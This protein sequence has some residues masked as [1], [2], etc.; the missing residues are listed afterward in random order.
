MSYEPQRIGSNRAAYARLPGGMGSGHN[1]GKPCTNPAHDP[2]KGGHV[3]TVCSF[4]QV[5]W[6]ASLEPSQAD[7]AIT[8]KRKA[9]ARLP[10]GMGSGHNG[11]KPCTNS[12]H[13]P[14]KGGNVRAVCS[15]SHVHWDAALEP[16]QA[17]VAI[18]VALAK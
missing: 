16:S 3:R 1:G 17:E 5:H 4:S 18:A 6:D 13:D 7:I 8:G 2:T 10:G 11:G 15:F 9:Y 12:A 14:T